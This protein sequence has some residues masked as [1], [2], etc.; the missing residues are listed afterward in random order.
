MREWDNDQC[1]RFEAGESE[2][3]VNT[4]VVPRPSVCPLLALAPSF[5]GGSSS[6]S[7]GS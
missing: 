6:Q 7:N 4:P 3:S 2:E 1:D 5:M